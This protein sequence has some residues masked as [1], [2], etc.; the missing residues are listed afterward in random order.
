MQRLLTAFVFALLPLAA[1]ADIP[2]ANSGVPAY[3]RSAMADKARGNDVIDDQRR[4]MAAVMMFTL[5]KP[6]DKVAEL[7]PGRDYW[8]IVFSQIVGSEGHVYTIWPDETAKY[9]GKGLARLARLKK[10]PR[11]SNISVLHQKAANFSVPEKVDLVFTAQNYHDYHNADMNVPD[12]VAFNKKVYD[13]LKPGGH[14]VIIDHVAPEGSGAK[15]TDTL[16]RIDPMLV[17]R[18]V[19]AAGFKFDGASDALRNPQDTHKLSV[20]DKSIRGR[21]DQFIYRFKKPAE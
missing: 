14:Y 16:H 12:M 20:F 4:Q 3:V 1:L 13:A 8:T 19:E 17:K 18:E 6:G 7:I 5:V 10:L 15:D 11:F 21:T 9:A 2:G